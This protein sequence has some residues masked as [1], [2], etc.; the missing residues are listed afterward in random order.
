VAEPSPSSLAGKRIVITRAVAQSDSLADALRARGAMVYVTPLIKIISAE[1]FAD[2]D[3]GLRRLRADDWIFLTS[4]NAVH[5]VALRLHILRADDPQTAEAVR[6][7][8]VGPATQRAAEEAAL[9]VSYVA[10]AH[11]G[12]SLAHEL[13]K[14][15]RGR[16]VL[17]PRSDIAGADLPEALLRFGATVLEIVAYRTERVHD[18]DVGLRALISAHGVD[19]IICFS[20]STVFAL[21]DILSGPC[22]G[23]LQQH[24]VFAAIGEST[25]RAF[26][27][28]GASRPLIAS[29]ATGEAIVSLLATH[30]AERTAQQFEG[31]KKS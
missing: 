22:I 6:I 17:L 31:A 23:D 28:T 19:A 10:R 5:P 16:R 9:E 30:F 4:Q 27:E 13:E 8:A 29:E 24:I 7:A 3:A 21:A 20:P 14:D 25:A 11:D 1:D 15:L 12:V 26:R 2:L 18:S